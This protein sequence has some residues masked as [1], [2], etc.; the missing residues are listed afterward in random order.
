MSAHHSKKPRSFSRFMHGASMQA[1]GKCLIAC[2]HRPTIGMRVAVWQRD[3]T[4][5][6]TLAEWMEMDGK[7]HGCVGKP[8]VW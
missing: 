7:A 2:R 1:T 3:S 6:V 4:W 8:V 5:K